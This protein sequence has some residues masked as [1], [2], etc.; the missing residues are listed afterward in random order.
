MQDNY[1]KKDA[2]RWAH[3]KGIISNIFSI[4]FRIVFSFVVFVFFI[5]YQFLFKRKVVIKHTKIL[6][7]TVVKKLL[8]IFTGLDQ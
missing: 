8:P 4:K 1:A 6:L 2:K 3:F 5:G 7:T